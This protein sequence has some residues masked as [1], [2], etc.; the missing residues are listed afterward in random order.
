MLEMNPTELRAAA[1]RWDVLAHDALA[2]GE[3]TSS[4]KAASYA[5]AAKA[6]RIWSETGVPVCSCCFKPTAIP[7]Y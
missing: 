6:L 1:D 2:R 5:D 7:S 3:V 4:A